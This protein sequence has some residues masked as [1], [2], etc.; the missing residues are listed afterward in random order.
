MAA[1]VRALGGD[2]Y[3]D[4]GR[5]NVP[6]PGHSAADRSVSLMLSDGR[7]IAH[8]FAGDGWRAVLDDLFE[9]GLVDRDG[10]LVDAGVASAT[11]GPSARARRAIAQDLWAEGRPITGTLSEI[12]LRRRG[13]ASAS[14]TL[15]HHP[16]VPAAVYAARGLRRPALLA[17]ITAPAGEITGLEVTYLAPNGGRARMSLARKTIGVRA[18][19][20]AVRLDPPAP[21]MLVGEGIATCLS[22]AARFGLPAWALLSTGNLRAWR[23]PPGVEFVLIAADRGRDGE[24]SAL[25]LAAALRAMGVR[26]AVRWPPA[27]FG[28]WNEAW[29]A[30]RE[31]K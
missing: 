21:R 1:I 4:G 15:R 19:G 29:V 28:D 20:S 25:V 17:A 8:S 24:R 31:G 2:L 23:P 6:G 26:G 3:A 22:A 14:P 7:V 5:A 16:G 13:V 11:S 10:R 18:S 30:S 12:H 27:P 9:R